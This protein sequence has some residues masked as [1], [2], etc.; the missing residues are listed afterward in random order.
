M[1]DVSVQEDLDHLYETVGGHGKIDI[2]VANAGGGD[3]A[4]LESV[5]PAQFDQISDVNVKGVLFTVQKALPYLTDGA[6]IILIG[7]TQGSSGTAGMSE[8]NAAKAAIR[9]FARS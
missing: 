4:A 9:S 5:T 2:V 8:Y 6:S 1:A 7:S 3:P